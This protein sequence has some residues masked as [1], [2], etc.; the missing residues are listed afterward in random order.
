MIEFLIYAQ[1]TENQ[2]IMFNA[3]VIYLQKKTKNKK[4]G[5][6]MCFGNHRWGFK[7][8]KPQLLGKQE[9]A[10]FVFYLLL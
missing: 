4:T 2:S 9:L 6:E 7:V 1:K 3:T 8:W 10:P 5:K